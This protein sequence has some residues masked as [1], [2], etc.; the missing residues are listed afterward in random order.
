[1]LKIF[2]K[3]S[4]PQEYKQNAKCQNFNFLNSQGTLTLECHIKSKLKKRLINKKNFKKRA[5]LKF[6]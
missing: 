6:I 1:M 3:F 5:N 4:N 2:T